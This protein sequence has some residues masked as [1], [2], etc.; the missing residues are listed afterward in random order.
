MTEYDHAGDIVGGDKIMGDKVM[1]DSFSNIGDGATVINKSVLI[2]S[3][4]RV[5]SDHGP[6][7]ADALRRVGEIVA[8]SQNEEAAEYFDALS[9]ELSAETPKK[10]VLKSLWLGIC[11]ALPTVTELTSLG[12]KISTLFR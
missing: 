1:G 6:D 10:T 4:N 12:E 5:R 8:E 9:A 3:L 7:V 11:A 2:N